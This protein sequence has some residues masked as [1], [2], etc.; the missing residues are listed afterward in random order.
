MPLPFAPFQLL[1]LNLVTDGV[2]GLGMSVEPAERGAMQRP[3]HP[4]SKGVFARVGGADHLDG[5]ADRRA[6]VGVAVW[7]WRTGSGLADDGRDDGHLRPGGAGVT[8]RSNAES[9]FRQ[10]LPNKP[11]LASAAVVVLS[12]SS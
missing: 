1:W 9:L 6:R 2:L 11:L 5:D 12:S 8:I 10:G 7:G 3:P 4:P